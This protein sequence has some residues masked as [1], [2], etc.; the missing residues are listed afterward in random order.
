MFGPAQVGTMAERRTCELWI[1][2]I[3]FLRAPP[4]ARVRCAVNRHPYSTE[5]ECIDK[6]G[7]TKTEDGALLRNR[8]RGHELEAEFFSL[9]V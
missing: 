5:A 9:C 1:R 3:T 7:D 2:T 6:L 8:T 4:E